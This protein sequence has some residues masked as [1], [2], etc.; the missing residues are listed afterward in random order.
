MSFY[1]EMQAVADTAINE[2]GQKVTV[3][4]KT[5]GAYDPL[6]ST[7]AISTTVQTGN[8]V[9]FDYTAIKDGVGQADGTLI[10]KGD[11]KLLLSPVGITA[12]KIDDTVVANGITYIIKNIKSINPAGTVVMY[13][14]QLR[15]I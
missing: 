15:G 8:G 7:A 2:Y 9:I 11:R 12:P 10:L 1:T 6:T 14:C 5:V 4:H 13:E 3:T